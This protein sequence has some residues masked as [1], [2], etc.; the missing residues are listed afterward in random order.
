MGLPES[1]PWPPQDGNVSDD[2]GVMMQ[3]LNQPRPRRGKMGQSHCRREEEASEPRQRP[4]VLVA[5]FPHLQGVHVGDGVVTRRRVPKVSLCCA[6]VGELP[7][8]YVVC[9]CW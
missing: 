4:R 2:S 3:E 9:K 1:F 8:C 5:Q 7:V 6:S